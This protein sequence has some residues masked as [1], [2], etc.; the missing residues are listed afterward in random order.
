MT[1]A[2]RRLGEWFHGDA[3]SDE[4]TSINFSQ[5]NVFEATVA[6]GT[7]KVEWVSGADGSTRELK[8]LA[9]T[10]TDSAVISRWVDGV[11]ATSGFQHG[12]AH[13]ITNPG[14][15]VQMYT[16]S[17]TAKDVLAIKILRWDNGAADFTELASLSL[18]GMG[19]NPYPHY[20]ESQMVGS[21]IRARFWQAG[22]L[23]PLWGTA[24]RTFQATD[25]TYTSGYS[26]IWTGHLDGAGA[27]TEWDDIEIW[28]LGEYP[29]S[30]LYQLRRLGLDADLG[31]LAAANRWAGTA[32]LGLLA[33]L[34]A[35]AGTS[36]LGLQAVCNA[37][38][39]TS[40]LAPQAA[41]AR[42]EH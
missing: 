22:E 37:L 9:A 33:A 39:G 25:A 16:V 5:T 7:G 26:G 24:G 35:K 6:G 27:H 12:H 32:G 3:W 14:T 21:T 29:G 2:N 17:H 36:G 4:F 20:C 11:S 40:G 13:R 41:L 18:T 28:E 19:A 1:V 38:A 15:S 8:Y 34:N 30:L 31:Q 10:L 42:I 23:R